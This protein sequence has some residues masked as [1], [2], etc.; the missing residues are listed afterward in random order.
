MLKFYL[1]LRRQ[2]KARNKQ[3]EALKQQIIKLEFDL[4]YERHLSR[5]YL[6]RAHII[7]AQFCHLRDSINGAKSLFG[8]RAALSE[9]VKINEM[10]LEEN[11]RLRV[12]AHRSIWHNRGAL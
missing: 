12:V 1:K 9:P 2:I 8:H 11:R 5:E 3:I 10:L 4:T 6:E 7:E